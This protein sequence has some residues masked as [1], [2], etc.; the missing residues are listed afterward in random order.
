MSAWTVA[1]A[2]AQFSHLLCES[3]TMPQPIYRHHQLVAAVIDPKTYQKMQAQQLT[4]AQSFIALRHLL[5]DD[6]GLPS[7]ERS[8]RDND[9]LG[10]L[11][12][13]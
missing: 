6:Q 7:H 11:N 2:R 9:F 3:Q 12:A 1:E 4:L 13:G 8:T 5:Q 10:V